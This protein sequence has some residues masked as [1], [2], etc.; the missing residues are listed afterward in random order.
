MK[1]INN[2]KY[3]SGGYF[4]IYNNLDIYLKTPCLKCCYKTT[5]TLEQANTQNSVNDK[6]IYT[7][8]QFPNNREGNKY[9]VSFCNALLK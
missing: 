2:T 3:T 8:N 6:C 4:I 1:Q 7:Y 9:E 5:Y